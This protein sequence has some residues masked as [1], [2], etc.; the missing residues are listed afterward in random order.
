MAA[1]AWTAERL[2]ETF[3]RPIYPQDLRHSNAA[4]VSARSIDANPAGNPRFPSELDEIATV[5]ARMAPS[6]LRRDVVLDRTDA[7]VQRLSAAIDRPLRDALI[8]ASKP[9]DPNAPLVAFVIHGAVYV[10]ASIVQSHGGVWGVRRPL[11]ESVVT[12]E[13]RAGKGDLSPFA[14]WLKS[15]ADAEIDRGGLGIRYRA[16][17]ERVTARPEDLPPIVRERADR[18]LPPLRAVRYDL[19][20]KW[21]VTHLPEL[22]DLGRDFPSAEQL[23]DIGFLSL[24]FLLLAGGR[25]LLMHGRGKAGLHLLWL[26]Y[27][28]FSHALFFPADPGTPHSVTLDPEQRDKLVVRFER[29]HVPI[30]HEL[31]YWG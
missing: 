30:E 24:E 8:A 14:W 23:D 3:F 19:L 9:G 26:D 7:S 28:G 10:G 13:S 2:F 5:F 29:D 17:V 27:S 1:D 21:L 25:L 11:W 31:L 15:L 6:V 18:R 20:H 12:L 4:M 16:H 22:R